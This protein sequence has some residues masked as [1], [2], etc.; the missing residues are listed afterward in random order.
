MK[1]KD[2]AVSLAAELVQHGFIH[3]DDSQVID[4]LIEKDSAVGLAEEHEFINEDDSLLISNRKSNG[5]SFENFFVS[6][7]YFLLE[8]WILHEIWR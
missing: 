8:V 6:L 4:W 7:T 5:D 3:E 2:S 1:E